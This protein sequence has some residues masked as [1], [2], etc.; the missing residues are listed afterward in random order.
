MSTMGREVAPDLVPTFLRVMAVQQLAWQG[1]L[2]SGHGSLTWGEVEVTWW[3]HNW[4]G[5]YNNFNIL[6]GGR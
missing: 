2:E 4:V 6:K 1:Q 3:R 5:F